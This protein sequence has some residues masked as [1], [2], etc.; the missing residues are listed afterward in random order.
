MRTPDNKTFGIQSIGKVHVV[1]GE[2][3]KRRSLVFITTR[4]KYP[5]TG[6]VNNTQAN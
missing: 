6:G 5:L 1:P 3:N 4:L 2:W